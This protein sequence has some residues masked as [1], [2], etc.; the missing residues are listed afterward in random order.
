[1]VGNKAC[2]CLIGRPHWHDSFRSTVPKAADGVARIRADDLLPLPAPPP[3]AARRNQAGT[4]NAVLSSVFV[5]NQAHI[6]SCTYNY[7][8]FSLGGAISF[9]DAY[10]RTLTITSSQFTD[11]SVRLTTSSTS[12]YLYATAGAVYTRESGALIVGSR[13]DNNS[14]LCWASPSVNTQS[15]N[16]YGGVF[17]CTNPTLQTVNSSIFV[18][19]SARSTHIAY[20]GAFNASGGSGGTTLGNCTFRLN[21][22]LAS[23]PKAADGGMEAPSTGRLT[24]SSGMSTS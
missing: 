19:N 4:P 18:G 10:S 24:R 7:Y 17:D 1:M 3:S 15:C 13:F 14:A 6:A 2:P 8:S 9:R 11:N 5:G 21:L 23:G 20:G 22:A 16:A 12:P